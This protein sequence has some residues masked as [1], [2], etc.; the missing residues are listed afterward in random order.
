M[1]LHFSRNV[2][3]HI[4]KFQELFLSN[5]PFYFTAVAMTVGL[6]DGHGDTH[7]H[8]HTHTHGMGVATGCLKT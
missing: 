7:T 6:G 4:E 3:I 2:V 1:F 5:V 8:T